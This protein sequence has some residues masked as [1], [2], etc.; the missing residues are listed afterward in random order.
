[1]V[2]R[3][4]KFHIKVIGKKDSETISMCSAGVCMKLCLLERLLP[5]G[6]VSNSYYGGRAKGGANIE[7]KNSND[8]EAYVGIFWF[9]APG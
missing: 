1:M 7:A 8:L 5:R 2:G 6:I 9:F 4:R 3:E